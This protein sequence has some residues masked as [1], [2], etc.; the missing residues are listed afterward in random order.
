MNEKSNGTIKIVVFPN[1][2]LFSD[3]EDITALKEGQVHFIATSTAKLGDLSPEWAVL[4]L[5]FAF[6]TYEAI[7]EG[8]HGPIGRSFTEDH[9]KKTVFSDSPI[10]Q[11]VLNKSHQ[12][13]VQ[14]VCLKIYKDKKSEL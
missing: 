6:P 10:G 11:M 1:G 13:K 7:E 9:C 4:D 3:I 2:S 5:P 12:I 8:I 14:F